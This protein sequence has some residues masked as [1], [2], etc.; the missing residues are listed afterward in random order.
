MLAHRI[1]AF[2]CPSEMC[3]ISLSL[4]VSFVCEKLIQLGKAVICLQGD[5]TE[6]NTLLRWRQAAFG[7]I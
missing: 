7:S 5:V 2:I 3:L 4:P 1:K 6:Q